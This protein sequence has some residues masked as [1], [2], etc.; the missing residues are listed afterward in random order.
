MFGSVFLSGSRT[1]PLTYS[2]RWLTPTWPRSRGI[3]K[4]RQ[5]PCSLRPP[6]SRPE[7]RPGR[8]RVKFSEALWTAPRWLTGAGKG[9]ELSLVPV[10]LA[11][12]T[13]PG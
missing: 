11:G 10:G 8:Y 3:P 9:Q 4:N 2:P 12:D 5:F 7:A 6:L 1:F 13:P